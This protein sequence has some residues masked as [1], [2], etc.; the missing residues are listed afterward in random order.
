[1]ADKN[2]KQRKIRITNS[3]TEKYVDELIATGKWATF[4]ALANDVF[5]I[6]ARDIYMRTFRAKE[7]LIEH[8]KNDRVERL[9]DKVGALI[10]SVDTVSVNI[11]IVKALA[12]IGYTIWKTM[13]EGGRI[14]VD[15]INA[16]LLLEL[17]VCLQEVEDEMLS[18][19]KK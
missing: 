4:N 6:G 15:E 2:D 3:D 5:D 12:Q 17:P 18:R 7:Y 1:M 14:S 8:K 10:E 16:G 11:E 9:C 19:R 13:Q